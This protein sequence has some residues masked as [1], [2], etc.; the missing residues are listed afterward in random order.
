MQAF[1]AGRCGAAPVA[2]GAI[3]RRVHHRGTGTARSFSAVCRASADEPPLGLGFGGRNVEGAEASGWNQRGRP[4]ILTESFSSWSRDSSARS[5]SIG[6]IVLA[7]H[8]AAELGGLWLDPAVA[9]SYSLEPGNVAPQDIFGI[10]VSAGLK[11][12]VNVV[13]VCIF[14]FL[15]GPLATYGWLRKRTIGKGK[16]ETL[17]GFAF[18]FLFFPGMVLLSP[19]LNLR[20]DPRDDDRMF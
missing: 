4:P 16:F 11:W 12:S 20:P 9:K 13:A 2:G 10:P 17:F 19:F 5:M 18:V 6:G 8:G 7:M 3:H 15:A 1:A 14:Y